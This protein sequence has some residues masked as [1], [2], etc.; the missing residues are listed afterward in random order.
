MI[1]LSEHCPCVWLRIVSRSS[2]NDERVVIRS[3]CLLLGLWGVL[4]GGRASL[5][6][7]RSCRVGCAVFAVVPGSYSS[8][9]LPINESRCSGEKS[10]SGSSDSESPSS[11]VSD[12]KLDMLRPPKSMIPVVLWDS[13]LLTLT[14]W[15][16]A[17]LAARFRPV[18]SLEGG[19]PVSLLAL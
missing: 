16:F 1:L 14:D 12:S 5:A 15:S 6:V 2:A 4:P 18:P 19:L 7:D 10:I 11:V 8:K 17:K 9:E 13:D 3:A